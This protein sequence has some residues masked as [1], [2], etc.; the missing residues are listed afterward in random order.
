MR[1]PASLGVADVVALKA[2]ER[3]RM[4][5]VKSTRRGMYHSFGPADREALSE[6]AAAADAD[7]YLVWWP[8]HSKPQWVPESDWPD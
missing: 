8:P 1:A 7:A 5:E 2:G 6:V 4:I 3:P